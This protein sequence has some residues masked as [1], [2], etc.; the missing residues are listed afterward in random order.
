[1][2]WTRR[3][4]IYYKSLPGQEEGNEEFIREYGLGFI[5][6]N[7]NQL[8]NFTK[9]IIQNPS[10][11]EYFQKNLSYQRENMKFLKIKEIVSHET[12]AL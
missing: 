9:F 6:K 10:V 4:G 5:A 12:C 1:L 11:L 2:I 7:F 8:A 3:V